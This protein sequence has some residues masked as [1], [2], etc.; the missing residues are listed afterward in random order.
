[1]EE[2]FSSPNFRTSCNWKVTFFIATQFLTI[3][4]IFQWDLVLG[5]RVANEVQHAHILPKGCI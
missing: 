2:N 5:G 1:M 4:H 3:A